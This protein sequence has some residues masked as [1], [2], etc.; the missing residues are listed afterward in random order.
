[1]ADATPA[2]DPADKKASKM[3]PMFKGHTAP[4]DPAGLDIEP[5]HPNKPKKCPNRADKSYVAANTQLKLRCAMNMI[6]YDPQ[7]VLCRAARPSAWC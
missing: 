6:L 3:P 2:L 5:D 7:V 1:M 4:D